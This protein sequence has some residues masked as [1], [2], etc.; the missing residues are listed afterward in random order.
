MGGISEKSECAE[1]CL[2]SR[3]ITISED[4]VKELTWS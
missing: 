1:Q 3:W 2:V 4:S